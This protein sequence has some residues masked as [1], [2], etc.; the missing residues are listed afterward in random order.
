VTPVDVRC[1]AAGDGWRCAATIGT[2]SAAMRYDV[3]V[4]GDD[5]VRLAAARG[6]TD[7]ERLVTEAFDFLLEREPASSIL[8]TFDLSVV[9]TYFPEFETEM[10]SRLAP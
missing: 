5:A 10:A 3:T 6:A 9:G 4:A 1:Q 8:R 2:G 7:V